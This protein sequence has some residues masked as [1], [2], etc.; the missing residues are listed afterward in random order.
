MTASMKEASCGVKGNQG[1]LLTVLYHHTRQ[2]RRCLRTPIDY[3]DLAASI[4]K[5]YSI[6][7]SFQPVHNYVGVSPD[8]A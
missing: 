8:N 3:Y 6:N 2:L 4:S 1:H 7:R 5:T